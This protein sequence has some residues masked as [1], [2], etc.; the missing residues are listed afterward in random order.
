MLSEAPQT[1]LEI[2]QK[3][4]KREGVGGLHEVKQI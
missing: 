4:K 3:E 2:S 1:S